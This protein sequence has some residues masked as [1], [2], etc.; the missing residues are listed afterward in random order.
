MLVSA[1]PQLYTIGLVFA[2]PATPTLQGYEI[3][4]HA[5][6]MLATRTYI[7]LVKIIVVT[8]WPL[9]VWAQVPVDY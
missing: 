6:I 2:L 8:S 4:M 3:Y 9:K 5:I 7:S 1:N